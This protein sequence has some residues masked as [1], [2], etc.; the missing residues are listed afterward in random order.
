MSGWT[1]HKTLHFRITVLF[2]AL[3]LLLFV[4][5]Y[6]WVNRTIYE[7]SWAPGEQEWYEETK[8][9]EM[10]SLAVLIGQDAQFAESVLDNYGGAIADFDVEL[11]LVGPG[12]A[13][14][15]S[16]RPDSLSRVLRFVDPALLDSMSIDT[17]DYST[18]PEPYDMDDFVNRITAVVPVR[19]GGDTLGELE[20]WLVSSFKPLQ[21]STDDLDDED[22]IRRIRGVGAML[23]YAFICGLVIMTWVSRRIRILSADMSAF[24]KGDYA[25]RAREGD[26]DEIATLGGDF[27][28]MAEKL[29][30]VIARLK[31]SEGYRK[32]LVANISHDLRTPMASLRG[33]VE[34]LTLHGDDLSPENRQRALDTIAANTDNLEALIDRLFELTYLESGRVE[35][36]REA[37]SI[38]ELAHEVLTRCEGRADE[39]SIKLHC[40]VE[41]ELPL[42]DADPLRIGQ[43]LQN[44]VENA[45][46]FNHDGGEVHLRVVGRSDGVD[47]EVRDTGIGIA[48]EDLP[49]VFERFYTAEKSRTA[50]GAGL[51]LAI[52]HRI[53]TGHGGELTVESHEGAGTAFHFQLPAADIDLSE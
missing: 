19:A 29:N 30:D 42:V 21:V 14:L 46:K 27:N 35:Y 47:L 6:K 51:G 15:S 53:V 25:H 20:G 33:H 4:G 3:L 2:L 10:D 28:R 18:Y 31:Q 38:E 43:V 16:T 1:F 12:G 36:R 49:H 22:D 13:V 7:V 17:W 8:D 45:V 41:G 26:G 44:L 34:T 11:A 48:S 24:R 52:A 39:R 23:L 5:Y 50:K 32:Q 37:F 40:D 9:A